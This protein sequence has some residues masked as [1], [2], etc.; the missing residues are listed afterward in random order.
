MVASPLAC[1]GRTIGSE[2]GD[3]EIGDDEI[4]PEDTDSPSDLLSC[5]GPDAPSEAVE[6]VS[7]EMQ[8]ETFV[9]V[10]ERIYWADA[11][12]EWGDEPPSTTLYRTEATAG[13]EWIPVAVD[14][15]GINEIR[16][17]G[18]AVYWVVEGVVQ[19]SG[20]LLR[21]NL[22]DDIEILDEGLL[23]PR[24]LTIDDANE[25][26]YYVEG[27]ELAKAD[28]K[29]LRI[30]PD[31]GSKQ[32]LAES[33][34]RIE[35]LAVD[36]NHVWWVSS[37]NDEVW[38]VGKDGGA[39]QLVAETTFPMQIEVHDGVGWIIS[40]LGLYRVSAGPPP[41]FVNGHTGPYEIA[42][43]SSHV[44]LTDWNQFE[45]PELGWVHRYPLSDGDIDA[46]DGEFV[47]SKQAPHPTAVRVDE[48][49]IYWA[50]ADEDSGQGAIWMLCKSAL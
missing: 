15:P 25:W 16:S 4:G 5:E 11:W 10:G 6:L 41:Y 26:I 46:F 43:D 50:T 28:A 49:A 9:R 36:E 21:A 30:R 42:A 44:Y 45:D 37:I 34:G 47:T 18:E 35:D 2:V 48:H 27:G 14:Q 24:A 7:G 33:L 8:P 13:G 3:D 22:D 32:L 17:D 20:A 29:V 19:P 38:R 40:I 23:R 1:G 39:Q 12:D 31:G